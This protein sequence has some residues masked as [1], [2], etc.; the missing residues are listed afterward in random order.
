[1]KIAIVGGGSAG[2]VT[3]HLLDG[4]HDVTIFEKAP[5]L[6]GHVRTLNRNVDCALGPGLILDAG[7]IEF[8]RDNFPT[9]MRLFD[10][11]GCVTRPVP[12]NTTFWTHDG[13]HHLSPDSTKRSGGSLRERLRHFIDLL[14]L[15]MQ[16]VRFN[17]RTSL[18]EASLDGLTLGRSAHRCGC[19]SLGRTARHL[20]LL[21]PL[22]TG[23]ADACGPHDPDAAR[24]RARGG[25]GEPA[26]RVLGLPGSNRREPLGYG[27]HRCQRGPGGAQRERGEGTH[28]LGRGAPLRQDRIRCA[29]RPDS[30]VT[31]RSHRGRAPPLCCMARE[32]Y[33]HSRTPRSKRVQPAGG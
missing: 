13:V 27:A 10:S 11:L 23:T 25:V 15:R 5:V 19:G 33:P 16:E 18:P 31:R 32:P 8:E 26:R 17:R 22:R 3:A 30:G 28:G 24:L 12:G 21:D 7:V 20:R 4:A 1:M 29:S 14:E 6:G 9:L 2:L